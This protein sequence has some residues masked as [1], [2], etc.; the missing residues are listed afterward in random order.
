MIGQTISHYRI[1][2]K[3]GE[4]G[5]GLAAPNSASH[6][7]TPLFWVLCASLLVAV[8]ALFSQQSDLNNPPTLSDEEK[9]MFLLKAKVV[10]IKP[11]SIEPCSS[12]ATR[13]TPSRVPWRGAA[14]LRRLR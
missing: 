11:V 4:G 12:S 14:L 3:L 6:R 2:E 1:T 13:K 9:E 5:M 7:W 8:P 10:S